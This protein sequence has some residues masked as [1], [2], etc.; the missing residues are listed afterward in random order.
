MATRL[1]TGLITKLLDTGSFKDLFNDTTD[2]FFIDI[3]SGSQPTSAD[4]VPNG[5]KLVTLYSNGTSAPLTL[6]ASATAGV[7]EKNASET[8]SGTAVATGTAGWFRMRENADAGTASSTT[9]VRLDGAVSTSGAQMNLGSLTVTTG[10]P[11]VL[12]TAAFTLP[13]S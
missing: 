8:W 2:G 10:A 11:F 3:Y 9:A 6:E 1:S 12:S 4:D 7:I 5:T 13:Q